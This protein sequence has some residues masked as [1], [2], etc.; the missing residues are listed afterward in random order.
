MRFVKATTTILAT[1]V[2]APAFGEIIGNIVPVG[3]VNAANGEVDVYH[4][5]VT[6]N[7]TSDIFT[8][9]ELDFDGEFVQ[10]SAT[11]KFGASLPEPAAGFV[12][13]DTFATDD[14]VAPTA[15]GTTIDDATNLDFE[16]V[17]TLGQPWI[18]AGQTETIAVFSVATGS[19][20]PVFNSGLAVIDGENQSIVIPEPSSLGLLGLG[21]LLIAR[22]RRG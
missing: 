20:A 9:N 8:F 15:F 1:L 19:N 22:R 12:F 2:V 16:S 4:F 13:A 11:T 21:G 7:T 18:G 14:L 6:N 10:S 17:A 3:S 5:Q